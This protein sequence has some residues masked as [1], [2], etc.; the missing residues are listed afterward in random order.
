MYNLLQLLLVNVEIYNQ[1]RRQLRLNKRMEELD[2]LRG[3]AALTVMCHHFLPLFAVLAIDTYSNSDYTLINIFKYSPLHIT[4]GGHEAVIL[5]FVLSGFVLSLPFYSGKEFIYLKYLVKR[6]C[7]I[8]LPY[9]AALLF[10]IGIFYF[11]YAGVEGY[12]HKYLTTKL[13]FNHFLLISS[14]QTAT[15]NPVIWSLVHELR[16]SIIFPLLMFFIL[17]VNW[18]W[19]IIGGLLV[20]YIGFKLN[21][22]FLDSPEPIDYF[23]T[24]Q[25]LIMFISGA[26]LAKHRIAIIKWF[27]T[28]RKIIKWGLVLFALICYTTKWTF[29]DVGFFRTSVFNDWFIS[30]AACLFIIISISSVKISR[31]LHWKPIFFLG[32]I[33][34][35]L[36]LFHIL[37]FFVC[38]KQ[39]VGVLPIWAILA[40]A[41]I[42]AILISSIIYYCVEIPSIT[43][44]RKIANWKVFGVIPIPFT[45]RPL[46][47]AKSIN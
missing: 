6:I 40:I 5:F 39:F 41:S 27:Q 4:W 22:R 8:Y 12:W 19:N 36:Y 17:R 28:Q 15:M 37:L 9:L 34:Y 35:S 14:F 23:K 33:S 32:K 10:A 18:K 7:R 42:L 43:L 20:S 13:L 26:L 47:E 38:K 29:Y 24:F 2:S 11:G 3:L 25:Y 44:G 45:K 1:S 21:N 30:L 46:S 16:I 31:F